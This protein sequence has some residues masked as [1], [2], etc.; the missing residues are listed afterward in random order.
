MMTKHY[1]Q[2]FDGKQ[3]NEVL[4]CEEFLQQYPMVSVG[5]TFFTVE[6]LVSDENLLKRRIYDRI[7]HHVTTGLPKKVSNLL[8]VLRMEC[9]TGN[10]PL[11]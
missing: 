11:H 7:K 10:L 1:P 8:E 3:L 4:F 5:G 6:G 2:W 9:C